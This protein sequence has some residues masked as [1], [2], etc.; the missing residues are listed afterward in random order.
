MNE[1]VLKAIEKLNDEIKNILSKQSKFEKMLDKYEEKANNINEDIGNTIARKLEHYQI[2][3]G[4]WYYDNYNTNIPATGPQGPEGPQGPRGQE[5]RPLTFD[6]LTEEQLDFIMGRDG[7]PGKDGRDGK[8]GK[9]GKDGRDGLPGKDGAD[10]ITPEFE[11][12][13]IKSVSTYDPAKIELIKN[14]NKYVI[15]MDIPRGRPG[16]NG[17]KGADGSNGHTPVKGKDYYTESDKQEMINYVIDNL[18]MPTSSTIPN[19]LAINTIYTL[20]EAQTTLTLNLPSNADLGDN[21]E[22]QFISGATPTTLTISSSAGLSGEEI[23]PTSNT[24]YTIITSWEL[25]NS[26]MYGWKIYVSEGELGE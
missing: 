8:D 15:N 23:T 11:V 13:E 20:A 24:Q 22:V 16:A 4:Y 12:G 25:I 1:R 17:S 10:G 18:D 9:D 21:I 7:D 14:D 3:D 19:T 26:N 5:G 2:V 6:D